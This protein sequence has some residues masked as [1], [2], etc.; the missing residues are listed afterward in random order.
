MLADLV[1]SRRDVTRAI[2]DVTRSLQDWRIWFSLA[3]FDVK[4]YYRRSVLGPF[5]FTISAVV[6]ALIMALV[7][8]GLFGNP[9][10]RYLPFITIS[11][12][13]WN[14]TIAMIHGGSMCYISAGPTIL[15]FERPLTAYYLKLVFYEIIVFA[16]VIGIFFVVA[17][18]FKIWPGTN[19]LIG[20]LA[21]PIFLLNIAWMGL[22]SAILAARFRDIPPLLQNIFTALFWLSPVLY[23]PSQMPEKIQILLQFNPLTHL[24]AIVRDPL[25]N[26]PINPWNWVVALTLLVF[27]WALTFA[28]FVRFR[29]RI[30]YWI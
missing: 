10:K 16:H 6:I 4:Q 23:R 30:A 2:E 24:L 25:L 28:V 12:M 22:F 3:W 20:L 9:L 26:Q 8:G 13:L 21:L 7:M 15:Q 5:W 1:R 29:G 17:M 19:T 18:I 11:L 27:G 14:M